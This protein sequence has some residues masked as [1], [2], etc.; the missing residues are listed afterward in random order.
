MPAIAGTSTSDNPM[1]QVAVPLSGQAQSTPPEAFNASSSSN[2]GPPSSGAASTAGM[3]AG[4]RYLSDEWCEAAMPPCQSIEEA[5]R[6]WATAEDGNAAI[7]EL[8]MH[9]KLGIKGLSADEVKTLLGEVPIKPPGAWPLFLGR[10]KKYHSKTAQAQRGPGSSVPADAK[11]HMEE[12]ARVWRWMRP[13]RLEIFSGY[14]VGLRQVLQHLNTRLNKGKEA[15]FTCPAS[16]STAIAATLP[17]SSQTVDH[18]VQ[19]PY[20]V[21]FPPLNIP[22]PSHADHP[23]QS[24]TG[25]TRAGSIPPAHSA[26]ALAMGRHASNGFFQYSQ[27]MAR[28]PNREI[29]NS[30]R[31]SPY[32]RPSTT[33]GYVLF[34]NPALAHLSVAR[35]S[36]ISSPAN[37][38]SLDHVPLLRTLSRMSTSSLMSCATPPPL[39]R[40]NSLT[41]ISDIYE[42][43]SRNSMSATLGASTSSL[44]ATSVGSSDAAFAFS[45]FDDGNE[46]SMNT[47]NDADNGYADF[48]GITSTPND[49]YRHRTTTPPTSS[50]A[51]NLDFEYEA[52]I[53]SNGNFESTTSTEESSTSINDFDYFGG[54]ADGLT[55]STSNYPSWYGATPQDYQNA[56][57]A[58][59]LELGYLTDSWKSD[60]F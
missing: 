54:S 21:A 53:P 10:Y 2:G 51:S 26:S 13:S 8:K 12:A 42:A 24:V 23:P 22:H 17:G 57:A 60:P 37:D 38:L 20:S 49:G 28:R 39:S 6:T 45:N 59:W 14:D 1:P 55:E 44:N 46:E 16:S 36:A 25:P 43:E 11:G 5:I 34:R 4:P 29:A 56:A 3:P 15:S 27:P 41:S 35:T 18:P 32:P 47:M 58:Q 30:T 40:Q 19:A 52:P 9:G 7:A 31:M 48:A 50:N 33:P